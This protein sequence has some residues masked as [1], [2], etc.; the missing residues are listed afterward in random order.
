MQSKCCGLL[1]GGGE[2]LQDEIL[3]RGLGVVSRNEARSEMCLLPSTV[4]VVKVV[5]RCFARLS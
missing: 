4:Q 1:F 5:I 2:A 3:H